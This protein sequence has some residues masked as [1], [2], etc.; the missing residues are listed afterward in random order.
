MCMNKKFAVISDVHGNL[1]G[2]QAV[3]HRIKKLK[4]GEI[5]C[6]GDVIGYGADPEICWVTVKNACSLV[7]EGNH[8]AMLAGKIDGFHCSELGRRSTTWTRN[9]ISAVVQ[10]ELGS[11]PFRAER[12]GAAFY[13]SSPHD[14]GSWPYLNKIEHVVDNFVNDAAPLIF[15]GHTH[16]P[17]ITVVDAQTG[18]VIQDELIQRT[19]RFCVD[20]YSQRCYLNPGS[21]GQQRDTHTDVSFAVCEMDR[22]FVQ[23][24]VLRIPYRRFCAYKKLRNSGCDKSLAT[25]LIREKERRRL[26]ELLDYWCLRLCRNISDK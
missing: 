20:L 17:R 26:F 14:D 3:L 23:L 2:L 8:E 11:L 22:H 24:E 15:Y 9:H 21:A 10:Q 5:I 12:Y 6:L 13:H 18:T 19:R 4:V 16:R 25:Y 7:L 1:E